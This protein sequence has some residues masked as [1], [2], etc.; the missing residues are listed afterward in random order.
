ME[1]AFLSIIRGWWAVPGIW[2]D[3]RFVRIASQSTGDSGPAKAMAGKLWRE[4]VRLV[5]G[6]RPDRHPYRDS[7][8]LKAGMIGCTI[9]ALQFLTE[10]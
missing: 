8:R 3:K 1:L 6:F 4:R 2:W 9:A 5:L 10:Q 7:S